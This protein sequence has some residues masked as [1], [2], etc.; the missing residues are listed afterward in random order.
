MRTIQEYLCIPLMVD[1]VSRC[2]EMSRIVSL[3]CGGVPVTDP[4]SSPHVVGSLVVIS[5]TFVTCPLV[6]FIVNT[7]Q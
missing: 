5:L 3:V 4:R 7:T 6:P 1:V 2:R